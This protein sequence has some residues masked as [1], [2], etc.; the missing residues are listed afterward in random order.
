MPILE[1]FFASGETSLSVRRFSVHEGVSS[2]FTVSV[3]ARSPNQDIDLSVLVGD[4]AGLR[5]VSGMAHAAMGGARSWT[6]VCSYLEQV[7]AEPTGLA[8]YYLRIVPTLWLLTQ[9][10][11]HRIFQHKSIPD[12][13]DA[14]LSGWSITPTW[15]IAR[16]SYPKL[17]Y[18]AQYGE[19]DYAFVCRLLEEA[20]IAMTFPEVGGASQLTLR[21]ALQTT[22]PRAAPPLPWVDNPNQTA[23]KEFVSE[24]RLTREVRPGAHV[25]RDYDFRNPGFALLGNA[26]KAPSPEDRYEQ[27][28]YRPGAFLAEGGS[29]GDTPTADDKGVAR[30]VQPHGDGHATRGLAATRVDQRAVAFSTN[31]ADLQPGSA[32]FISGHPHATLPE[33]AKLLVTDMSFEGSHGESWNMSGQAV[34]TDVPYQPAA[35]TP[36]PEVDG[37]QSATVVGPSGQEIYT[38]EFGRV[39]LQFP[40]D[41]EGKSDDDS[42]TGVRVSQGWAGVGYG[43]MMIPRVGQEVLVGFL[44]GDPDQP[45]VVGRVFNNTQRVPYKLPDNKTR[46]TWKSDSSPGSDGFNEIMFEDLKD[47]EL[48][49]M[50]AQKNLRKLVKNDETVTIGNNL[51]KLVKHDETETTTNDRTEVTGGSR[52]EITD[53]D[54][55]TS[56]GGAES[57]MVSGDERERT[58]GNMLLT[59]GGDQHLIVRQVKREK[60]EKDTHLTVKGSRNEQ[61]GGTESL[62]AGSLQIKVGKKHALEAGDEIHIKS[63]TNLV[64]EAASSLTLKGP[65]GF[66]LIDGGG[67]TIQGTLVKINSGGS[68]GSGTPAGPAAPEDPLEAQVDPPQKPAP[69]DVS[70]TRIAQ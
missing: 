61:V 35:R 37:V 20:G 63:A 48:V 4:A 50:Q 28:H 29:G 57:K 1:L 51:Q 9:R 54:S 41:R 66:I 18:K 55:T 17:E 7:Q 23:E 67:V 68:P 2:L 16:A 32:F 40:W 39:R 31:A 46:S 25:V 42:S 13:V 43:M 36:K 45:V 34:F 30:Y 24:V 60:V 27:F 52:T 6:G 49:W 12:I 8:T 11:N 64:L 70:K 26:P 44:Q 5:V 59:V 10:K 47:K 65:G 14:M 38:D 21:D 69:D 62:S 33:S 3:W 15:Q 58:L 53:G 22:T 56:I 19:T